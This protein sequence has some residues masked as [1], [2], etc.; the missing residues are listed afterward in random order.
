[1]YSYNVDQVTH[2]PAASR[3]HDLVR[4]KIDRMQNIS[5]GIVQQCW[6][7]SEVAIGDPFQPGALAASSYLGGVNQRQLSKPGNAISIRLKGL[8]VKQ[9]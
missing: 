3:R 8:C 9:G 6:E 2:F 7:K 5:E 1:M 4:S